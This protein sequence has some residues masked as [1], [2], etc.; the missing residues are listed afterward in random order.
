MS[1]G[2][3]KLTY[4]APSISIVKLNPAQAVLSVCS[5]TSGGKSA[6]G[7]GTTCRS[8]MCKKQA[9]GGDSAGQC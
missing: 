9:K 6:N 4:I 3:A 7:A 5:T 8:G 1:T 2:K